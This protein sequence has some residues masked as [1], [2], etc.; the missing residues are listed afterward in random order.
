[1]NHYTRAEY[2]SGLDWADYDDVLQR[3]NLDDTN[4]QLAKN[5][6]RVMLWFEHD[7]HDILVLAKILSV[8]SDPVFRPA[9]LQFICVTGFPGVDI[10]NGIGQL[11]PQA[12]RMLWQQFQPITHEQLKLGKRTWE[13]ITS[14]TPELLQSLIDTQT[15]ELP[16]FTPALC[17]HLQQLPSVH[18]G[19]NL[20]EELSLKIIQEKGAMNAARLFGWYTNHY[21]PLTFMGDSGY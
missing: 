10:F 7:S 8:F 18:N 21:E 12:L 20:T 1:M 9:N 15:L 11:P 17:R 16:P 3:V 13:G 4:L 14:P 19:L 5:Y 6:E 2:I